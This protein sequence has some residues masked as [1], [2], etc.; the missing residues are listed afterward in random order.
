MP[1]ALPQAL[2]AGNDVIV[3]EIEYF[4]SVFR[5]AKRPRSNEKQAVGAVWYSESSI[6][7]GDLGTP[8]LFDEPVLRTIA[9]GVTDQTP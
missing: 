4:M 1:R 7:G 6:T 9:G 8:S 3:G 2:S 5:L